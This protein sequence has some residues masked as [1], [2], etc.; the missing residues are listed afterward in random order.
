MAQ[1]VSYVQFFFE[2]DIAF[3]GNLKNLFKFNNKDTRT[4]SW[5][6]VHFEQISHIILVFLLLTLNKQM[7]AGL[8]SQ[9]LY[10]GSK[11][12]F[13]SIKAGKYI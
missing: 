9:I 5:C 2:L 7:P 13:R 6:L 8:C 12:R 1:S 11:K 10:S 4:T 3:W